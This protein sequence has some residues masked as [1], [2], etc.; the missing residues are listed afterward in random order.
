[1]FKK[2]LSG[3]FGGGDEKPKDAAAE[4]V[5]Y[6]GFQIVSEPAELG[7]LYRV[8]GWIRKPGADGELLEHRFERSDMVPG[9]EACD[10]L[11][12][13]KAQRFIDEVGD[14]MFT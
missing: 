6:K 12:I 9:R 3:L 14:E 7:G 2:L 11:M 5:E 13:S 4:P 8:S 1:M 10:Q